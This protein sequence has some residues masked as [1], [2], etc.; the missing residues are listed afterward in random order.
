MLE[1]HLS[2]LNKHSLLCD[3]ISRFYIG[4]G[5]SD[6]MRPLAKQNMRI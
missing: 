1:N 2:R 6:S 3:A 5:I 4:M